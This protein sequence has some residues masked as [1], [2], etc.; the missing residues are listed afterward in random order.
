MKDKE[1][2]GECAFSCYDEE[3]HDFMCNNIESLYYGDYINYTHSC[4]D[5]YEKSK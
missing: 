4:E 5:W 1:I 2:C 3:K